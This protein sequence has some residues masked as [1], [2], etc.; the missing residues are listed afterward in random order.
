MEYYI[1][2]AFIFIEIQI[3]KLGIN[4]I[5]Y[6]MHLGEIS[7]CTKVTM[8]ATNKIGQRDMKGAIKDCF[9]FDSFFSSNNLAEAAIYVVADMIG[10]VKTN[11]K[12]F[13]KDTIENL[14]NNWPGGS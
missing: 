11:T 13:C 14:T 4:N 3:G 6:H 7:F 2:G 1:T 10:M 8:T 5:K 9:V 12:V